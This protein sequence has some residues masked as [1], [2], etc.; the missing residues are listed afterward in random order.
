MKKISE[1][2]REYLKTI[3]NAEFY[4]NISRKRIKTKKVKRVVWDSYSDHVNYFSKQNSISKQTLLMAM[5]AAYS[6]MPTMLDI[7]SDNNPSD[8]NR[9]ARH[10]EYLCQIKTSSSLKKNQE[11][12]INKL[13]EIKA[14]INNSMVGTSKVLHMFSPKFIPII[15]SRVIRGWNKFFKRNTEVCIRGCQSGVSPEKY[16]EYWL[17]VL[18][19]KENTK[20]SVRV[21]EL[22]F[23]KYGGN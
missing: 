10:V 14:L 23:Y 20:K 13:S 1:L 19:W 7:Y 17:A 12:V 3:F 9:V 22:L 6:W 4:N 21:I 5:A 8:L 16:F 11:T 2:D 18:I 15:D